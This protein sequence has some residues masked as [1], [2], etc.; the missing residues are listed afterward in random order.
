MNIKNLKK[1]NNPTATAP[2]VETKKTRSVRKMLKEDCPELSVLDRAYIG[3]S[4]T[5]QAHHEVSKVKR[6]SMKEAKKMGRELAQECKDGNKAIKAGKT[7]EEYRADK[8]RNSLKAKLEVRKAQKAAKKA[9]ENSAD[10]AEKAKTIKGIL[11]KK[12]DKAVEKEEPKPVEN[13]KPVEE[14]KVEKKPDP[15]PETKKVDEKKSSADLSH[16]DDNK[17][18]EPTKPEKSAAALAA[19]EAGFV[20]LKPK[21]GKKTYPA[22]GKKGKD[23]D[24]KGKGKK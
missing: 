10:K 18:P 24:N 4:A 21:S 9:S 12:A 17:K 7:L 5:I 6:N 14:K 1:G 20:E 19:E 16:S 22:K 23:K 2:V 8:Q 11:N 3:V 13:V 15:K